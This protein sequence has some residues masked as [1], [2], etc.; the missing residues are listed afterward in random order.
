[1][2]TCGLEGYVGIRSEGGE[3]G[4]LTNEVTA[5]PTPSAPSPKD[6]TDH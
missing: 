4:Y 1:M 2:S 5:E 6:H 3:K